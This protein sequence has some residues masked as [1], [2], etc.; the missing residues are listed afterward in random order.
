VICVYKI[1][2]DVWKIPTTI[3]DVPTGRV[4]VMKSA[5]VVVL[6]VGWFF[7]KSVASKN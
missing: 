5:K 4:Y 7:V 3:I 6:S 1:F 2:I